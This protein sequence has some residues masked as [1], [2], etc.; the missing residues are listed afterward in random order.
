MAGSG[1]SSAS[2]GS[3]STE[4]AQ[5]VTETH[6]HDRQ[7]LVVG[8]DLATL[9]TAGFLEQA[10][11]DPVLAPTAADRSRS[12]VATLWKP[13]LDLL[14]RLG[15][16]RPVE[17]LGTPLTRL[18]CRGVATTWRADAAARPSLVSIERDRLLD[19]LERQL[20]N[21]VRTTD[22]SITAVEPGETGVDVTFD[23]GVDEPFDT[24]VTTDRRL[25]PG[26]DAT[27]ASASV[28]TWEFRWPDEVAS[29]A[30]VTESW[31]GDRAVF[32]VP[33]G[34]A[35][36]VGL[37]AADGPGPLPTVAVAELDD[38]F[39][40]LVPSAESPFSA[41]TRRDV[42]YT[43]LPRTVP[44]SLCVDGIALV[45]HGA[46]A[47]LPSAYLGAALAVEDAWVLAD[48]LAYGPGTM[49]DALDTYSARRRRRATEIWRLFDAAE[50]CS[51]VPDELS[52]LL[53]RLCTARSVAFQHLFES[54]GPGLAD[55][56]PDRL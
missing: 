52:P 53:Q 19:L 28:H 51:R 27:T 1:P 36:V 16:R 41:L 31:G 18:D 25:L 46:R 40:H 32:S 6:S 11:L 34:D 7:V 33:V 55:D 54:E 4:P 29:P 35:T 49:A 43:R 14:E 5:G 20:A 10:G 21:R 24:V 39:G 44:R 50:S 38:A 17:R 56:V 42:A 22:R 13:G 37:L 45:G 8:S 26:H 15:L 3:G 12:T 48:T 9:A 30:G 47:S 2:D 23:R